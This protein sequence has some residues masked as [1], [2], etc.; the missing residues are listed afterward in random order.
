MGSGSKRNIVYGVHAVDALIVR[1]PEAILRAS[2]LDRNFGERLARLEA[3]IRILGIPI[4]RVGRNEL[5]RLSLNGVHQGVVVEISALKEFT[6]GDFE[7]LVLRLG[8]AFKGLL[9]DGIQDPRNLG[10]CLRTADAAGVHAVVVPRRRSA[11]LTPVAVK[12]ATGA[13]ETLPIVRVANLAS[14]VH[15][16]KEAGVWILG[17]ETS[18]SKSLYSVR[19][20]TPL[21]VVIGGEGRGLRRL[22]RELC[23]ELVCIPTRGTVESLNV[24]VAAGIMLFEFGRRLENIDDRNVGDP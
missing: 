21:A 11:K 22:T 3:A 16:L 6:I 13:A 9:L 23:D 17:A 1:R 19:P 2:F 15:W 8:R 7:N 20:S 14:T 4:Q 18:A 5:D 12:A 10:A 24:S